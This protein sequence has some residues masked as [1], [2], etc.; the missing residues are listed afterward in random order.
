MV[1]R[2]LLVGLAIVGCDTPH[3]HDLNYLQSAVYVGSDTTTG[4]SVRIDIDRTSGRLRV[5]RFIDGHEVIGTFR[6]AN[7]TEVA[8]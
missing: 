1:L 3:C 5:F 4:G 8:R 7:V 2:P 6:I